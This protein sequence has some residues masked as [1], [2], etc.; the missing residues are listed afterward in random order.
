M[1]TAISSEPRAAQGQRI[2][3]LSA[4]PK[5]LCCIQ[6]PGPDGPGPPH[7]QDQGESKK[8]TCFSQGLPAMDL[9]GPRKAALE[10]RYCA[11]R[12]LVTAGIKLQVSSQADM[13]SPPP[14]N[15]A[16]SYRQGNALPQGIL[17]PHLEQQITQ[18][19]SAP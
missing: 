2:S 14:L 4:R 13:E 16:P 10:D 7:R 3:R 6:A 17:S 9:P 8:S 18:G 11:P 19:S 1:E 12:A 5:R 15:E